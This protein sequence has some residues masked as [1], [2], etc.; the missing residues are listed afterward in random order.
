MRHVALAMMTAIALVSPLAG[1]APQTAAPVRE[2]DAVSIKRFVEGSP[3]TVRMTPEGDVVAN[4]ITLSP[5]ISDAYPV[6][7]NRYLNLPDWVPREFYSVV[8][9]PPAGTPRTAL[10]DMWKA[11]L[12]DRMKLAAH[13]EQR[14]E[15]VYNLVIA[16]ADGRLGPRLK[17]VSRDCEAELAARKPDPNARPT[18]PSREMALAQCGSLSMPIAFYSGGVTLDAFAGQLRFRAGRIVRNRTGLPGY[19]AIELTHAVGDATGDA[20]P[21]DPPPFITALREQL[22]LKLEPDKVA[23]DVVVI[24]HIE[25]PTEN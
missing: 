24:D 14:D 16:N 15:P 6:D 10:P 3:T 2:F 12:R 25:R 8:A 7:S 23:M 11:V 22:G 19:Y 5:F 20:G 4:G 17:P 1:H 13:Y 21:G 9:K 18:V